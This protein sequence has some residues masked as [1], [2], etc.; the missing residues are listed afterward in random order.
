MNFCENRI[1]QIA[2]N[3]QQEMLIFL[4]PLLAYP[5]ILIY[6]KRI[7]PVREKSESVIKFHRVDL[8]AAS[9]FYIILPVGYNNINKSCYHVITK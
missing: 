1:N 7:I 2:K 5:L 8:F 9:L 6:A 4:L 3:R